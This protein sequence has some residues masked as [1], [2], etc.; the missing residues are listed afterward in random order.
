ML[1]NIEIVLIGV[2]TTD[3]SFEI[4]QNFKKEDNRIILLKNPYN[5]GTIK[6]RSEAFKLTKKKYILITDSDDGLEARIFYIITLL[7]EIYEIYML[8][9]LIGIFL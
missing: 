1:K 8:L 6:F 3:N 9:N 7:L 5:C 2:Y 4:M